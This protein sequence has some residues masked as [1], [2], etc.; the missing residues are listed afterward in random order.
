MILV[1]VAKKMAVASL[2]GPAIGKTALDAVTGHDGYVHQQ[3]KRDDQGRHRH[4]LQIDSQHI[5][6]A[7]GHTQ[8]D[9][10]CKGHDQRQTPF[11]KA[12]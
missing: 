6:N 8:R 3:A 12:D 7:E 10:N 4:L 11:P 5:G 9:R 1:S 2:V